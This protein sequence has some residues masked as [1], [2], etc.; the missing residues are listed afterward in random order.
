MKFFKILAL[1]IFSS[2]ISFYACNNNTKTQ[3]KET[4]KPMKIIDL[5]TPT[6]TG[7]VWHYTCSKGCAGGAGSA[8][9]CNT[10]G[11]LLVHNQAYHANTNSTPTTTPFST[12]PAAASGKNTSGVWHYTCGNG[13]AGGSGTAGNCGNCGGALAHNTAYHQ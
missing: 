10:C 4:A 7:S 5:P 11:T 3:K 9:N 6:L 12:P 1:L 8:V 2:I 13:C